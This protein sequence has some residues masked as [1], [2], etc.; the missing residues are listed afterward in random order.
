[1][2]QQDLL[3]ANGPGT[4]YSLGRSMTGGRRRNKV[5][6]PE[7]Y[8]NTTTTARYWVSHQSGHTLRVVNRSA[9]GGRWVSLAT[10]TLRG[11]RSYRLSLSD[12]TYE[13]YATRMIAFDRLRWEPR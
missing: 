11:T 8:N 3:A 6:I 5:S 7:R 12:M 4:P 1:M 13:T 2:G 10:Y 9:N